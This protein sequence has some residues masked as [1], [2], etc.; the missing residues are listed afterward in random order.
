MN[1]RT[2]ALASLALIPTLTTAY[3]QT[4]PPTRTPRATP[5]PNPTATEEPIEIT[6]LSETEYRMK[7][8]DLIPTIINAS[9]AVESGA[10]DGIKYPSKLKQK[11][12]ID[13]YVAQAITATNGATEMFTI[14]PPETLAL[15]HVYMLRYSRSLADAL[16][17]FT[18][19]L[20]AQDID[21]MI[22]AQGTREFAQEELSK[23]LY[24]LKTQ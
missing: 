8:A 10:L 9:R 15:G 20:D 13:D 22:K 3:A 17:A 19:A 24:L 5:R 4:K 21:A 7:L 14:D 11:K 6:T 18:K 16:D 12:W 1:R 23:A 2:F